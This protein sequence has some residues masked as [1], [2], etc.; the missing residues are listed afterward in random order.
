[1]HLQ[2]DTLNDSFISSWCVDIE[3]ISTFNDKFDH[4]DSEKIV[5]SVLLPVI[6]SLG[7][8]GN[9]ISI[10]VLSKKEFRETFHKLLICLA[11]DDIVFIICAIFT[12]IVRTHSLLEGD[13]WYI[14]EPIFL[15]LIPLGSCA[16]VT[17]MYLTVSISVE[18]YI[19]ICY[20]LQSRVF[21]HRR[22]IFYLMPVL[23]FSL[24]FNLPKF[25][26]INPNLG[27]DF[28]FSN[29]VMYNKIY[30]Q[31]IELLV[32]VVIPWTVLLYLNTRIYFAVTDKTF[33]EQ[34]V[35]IRQRKERSLGLILISIVLVFLIC[36]ALKVYLAFYKIHILNKTVFCS[37]K[38]MI[39]QH[40]LWLHFLNSFN[41][42]MLVISSSANFIIY[43]FLGKRFRTSLQESFN[44]FLP[45]VWR[46]SSSN[47][48]ELSKI[49]I[50][51]VCDWLRSASSVLPFNFG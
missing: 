19:G 50:F 48:G 39:P 36:H 37:E 28:E 10:M 26:E 40:P 13:L 9:L 27:V 1:M 49:F 6:G 42:L 31:Y 17:S 3:N 23:A 43:C 35:S 15:F 8:T 2:Q 22:L 32:T 7:V 4:I 41:H 44:F 46:N 24:L 33:R 21:G 38:G 16:L 51:L 34:N 12:C 5:E 47:Q 25:L 45:A 11:V 18:R 14:F 29:N 30:K 20:P